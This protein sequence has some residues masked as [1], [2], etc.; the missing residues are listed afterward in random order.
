MSWQHLRRIFRRQ[1]MGIGPSRIKGF[2]WANPMF[3]SCD[4]MAYYC[5]IRRTRPQ[6]VLEVGSGFSSLVALEALRANGQGQLRSALNHFLL[7]SCRRYQG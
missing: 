2:F 4:A 7:S 1:W 5:M 6:T 3:S